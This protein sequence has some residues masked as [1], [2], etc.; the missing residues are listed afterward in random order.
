MPYVKKKKAEKTREKITEAFFRLAFQS[1]GVLPNVSEI[2]ADMDIYRSTFYN[3]F[4][5]VEELVDEISR[6]LETE[7]DEHT[8]GVRELGFRRSGEM[9]I[10]LN[11]VDVMV[12]L[13]KKKR[14]EHAV[15]L[16]PELNLP[17]RQ[18]FSRKVWS[19]TRE[20][21]RDQP[22]NA[23]ESICDFV[24][25]GVMSS[26]YQWLLKQDMPIGEFSRLLVR[27]ERGILTSVR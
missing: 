24:T 2:C 22:Q 5:S 21:L 9:E 7:L 13:M 20:V 8:R 27:M 4:S 1:M 16:N 12:H 6:E 10:F 14:L 26:V 11:N 18:N 25:E 3:Y 19:A 23:A 15:L 17:F